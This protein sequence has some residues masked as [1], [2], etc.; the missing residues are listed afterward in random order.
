MAETTTEPIPTGTGDGGGAGKSE[1][2]LADLLSWD[3]EANGKPPVDS[4]PLSDVKS[5][6]DTTK[7]EL[8]RGFDERLQ[9]TIAERDTA[10]RDAQRRGAAEQE[11]ISF[12]TDLRDRMKSA[13]EDTARK[14]RAEY[15]ANEDRY[16]SGAA[17][18][19]RS[20]HETVQREAFSSLYSAMQAELEH[21]G[22]SGV[23]PKAGTPELAA[24]VQKLADFDG[25]GGLGG[26]L[27]EQGR[28][29]GLEEGRTAMREELER[30]GRIAKGAG[31]GPEGGGSG[32]GY[33]ANRYGDPKWVMEQKR[34]TSGWAHKPSGDKDDYG[35]DITNHDKVMAALKTGVLAAA[36]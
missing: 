15:E 11:D 27:I 6:F 12:Y 31:S 18:A 5:Y 10:A 23:L 13:D 25:K 33:S 20:S 8:E 9:R 4:L 24:F 17:A 2:T 3:T 16:L 21:A 34:E 14:A 32:G 29:R 7:S 30:D 1:P 35:R 26:Y 22:L 19:R 28:Q 36:R